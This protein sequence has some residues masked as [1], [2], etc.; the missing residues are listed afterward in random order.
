MT[1]GM[2]RMIY[3]L[4]MM[5]G[6]L[7]LGLF[8]VVRYLEG[9]AIFFPSKQITLTPDRVGLAFEDLYLTTPDGININAWLLKNTA[10]KATLIYA[11]GNAGA[12]SDRLMKIK[13]FHDL[14]LNVIVFDYR[15]FG[16]S[17]GKPNE[18]GVYLD[19]LTVFDY[20]K[21]RG[22]FNKIPVIAY[23]ASMGGVVAVDLATKRPVDIL[24]V[25][26]SITSGLEVAR[27]LYPY[28]PSFLITIRF[29]SLTKVKTLSIP[30]LF[31][32]S[33]Q[34]KGIAYEM[35]RRLYEAAQAPKEF[36]KSS[37][38]HDEIQIVSDH[39]T[40]QAFTQYLKSQGVL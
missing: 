20:L 37:G 29:D 17:Q 9:T 26:S 38:G 24:V 28:L 34:D 15:G 11:H 7:F 16:K 36:I 22:E 30:K 39:A 10:A 3:F 19:A 21:T 40:S 27:R 14:G 33:P 18:Q 1:E 4:I 12:M 35:G 8:L 31:I 23:G 13:Y 5:S 25:D 2:K 32:H 6:F